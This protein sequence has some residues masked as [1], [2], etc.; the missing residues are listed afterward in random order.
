MTKVRRASRPVPMESAAAIIGYSVRE[1]M[2][3]MLGDDGGQG[4]DSSERATPVR[5]EVGDQELQTLRS[6]QVRERKGEM[7]EVDTVS[8][9]Q[10]RM[11][12]VGAEKQKHRVG[13]N[14]GP[15][16]RNRM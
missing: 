1:L 16:T 14:A 12:K 3:K 2:Q 7:L 13:A 8:T 5:K 6:S 4:P 9:D 11:A 15:G 10:F